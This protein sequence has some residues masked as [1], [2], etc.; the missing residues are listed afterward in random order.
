[1]PP[2]V[3]HELARKRVLEVYKAALNGMAE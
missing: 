1:V 2:I 3:N